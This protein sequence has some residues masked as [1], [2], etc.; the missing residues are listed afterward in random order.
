M[1]ND[2][3]TETQLVENLKK[4]RNYLISEYLRPHKDLAAFNGGTANAMRYLIAKNNKNERVVI[5]RFIRFGTKKSKMIENYNRGGIL[6]YIDKD[7][8]FTN[9][10]IFDT[11]TSRNSIITKHPDHGVAL[12]GRIPLWEDVERIANELMDYMPQMKYLGIDF[13]ITDKCTVKILE[14]NSLTS[15]DAIKISGSILNE[16]EGDFFKELLRRN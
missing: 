14:I 2:E 16:P 1:N 12:K 13:V 9:G 4:L 11:S 10:N 15:L 5:T 3:L 7:G 6:S 8:Y